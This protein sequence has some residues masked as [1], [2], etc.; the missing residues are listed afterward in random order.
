VGLSIVVISIVLILTGSFLRYYNVIQAR[1]KANKPVLEPLL[2][3]LPYFFHTLLLVSWLAGPNVNIVHSEK[4]LWFCFYWGATFS[5]QVSHLILAH[6]T[7]SSFP[8]WNGMIIWTLM[9]AIDAN[10]PRFGL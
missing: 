6:I 5:Y 8:Y 9:G 4:I 1:R 10:L 2:G 7:K 3:L